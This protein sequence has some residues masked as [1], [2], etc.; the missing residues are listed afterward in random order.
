M[1]KTDHLPKYV[2]MILDSDIIELV[3]FIDYGVRDIIADALQWIQ[4]CLTNN[5]YTRKEDIKKKKP[6]ALAADNTPIITWIAL[7]NRPKTL[8]KKQTFS[9]VA[10]TNDAMKEMVS[11][12]VNTRMITLSTVN[13]LS[14]FDGW[15]RLT[16]LGKT[17]YWAEFDH[18][19]QDID[20]EAPQSLST[21]MEHQLR[22]Y[23]AGSNHH[24]RHTSD[25]R[26]LERQT[27]YNFNRDRDDH[28]TSNPHRH[29][30]Q[31]DFTSRSAHYH[32][33]HHSRTKE[34]DRRKHHRHHYY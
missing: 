10:K 11:K 9:L 29:R 4:N 23:P 24:P 14:H 21:G 7:V 32:C 28:R 34:E 1:N 26:G 16:P 31:D 19:M 13:E 5:F 22:S 18:Q 15:G 20:S 12:S 27:H 3:N 8:A 30:S 2:V 17:Q 33:S 25:A 6:R